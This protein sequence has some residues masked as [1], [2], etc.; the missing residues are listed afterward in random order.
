[1]KIQKIG[2]VYF[3]S[4]KISPTMI[5]SFTGHTNMEAI[6]KCFEYLFTPN[7]VVNLI[8]EQN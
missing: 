2:N 5:V 6:N 4:H 3:A 8:T 7:E 1:M